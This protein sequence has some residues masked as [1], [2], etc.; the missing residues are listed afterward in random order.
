[1]I[2]YKLTKDNKSIDFS[3]L[4][5]VALFKQTNPEWANIQPVEYEEQIIPEPQIVPFD[6]PTWRLRAILALDNLEQS[7]TDALNQL[8]EPQKTIAKRAWDYGS[9]TERSSPTV[10]FIKGVLSL[11]DAQ[12][13]DIFV[14]AEAIQI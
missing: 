3:S 13:D 1:M 2:K 11:T 14:Q 6:V 7:V 10:D 4:N 12:V 8:T 5:D 9:K